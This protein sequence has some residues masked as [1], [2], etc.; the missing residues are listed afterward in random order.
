MNKYNGNNKIFTYLKF[1]EIFENYNLIV[2]LIYVNV[3]IYFINNVLNVNLFINFHNLL[4]FNDNLCI[5]F[6]VYF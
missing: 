1:F 6:L 2:A 3:F 5:L 4:N